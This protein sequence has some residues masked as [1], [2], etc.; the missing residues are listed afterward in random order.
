MRTMIGIRVNEAVNFAARSSDL[1]HFK[2]L[3]LTQSGRPENSLLKGRHSAL[4]Q[5]IFVELCSRVFD[6]I[7]VK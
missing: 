7:E 3:L 6:L 4:G 1:N 5:K 2:R